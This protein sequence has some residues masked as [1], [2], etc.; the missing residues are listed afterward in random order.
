MMVV[1]LICSLWLG[2]KTTGAL[3]ALSFICA[4]LLLANVLDALHGWRTEAAFRERVR[5][6]LGR[7]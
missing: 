5:R 7:R 4:G 6:D 2:W 3:S 1:A